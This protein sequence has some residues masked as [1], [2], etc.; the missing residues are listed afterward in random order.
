M[1]ISVSSTKHQQD[2]CVCPG[3]DNLGVIS[4]DMQTIQHLQ[5]KVDEDVTV[6]LRRSGICTIIPY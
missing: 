4:P 2:A 3:G 1:I 5:G 6:T